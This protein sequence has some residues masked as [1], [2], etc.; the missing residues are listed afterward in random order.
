M[1]DAIRFNFSGRK[2][3]EA[4]SVLLKRQANNR[5]NY[6]RLLKLLYIADRESIRDTGFP[7]TGDTVYATKRGPVL[8]GVLDLIKSE[9]VDSALWD[10]YI[11]KDRY[12]I[13]IM[14]DPGLTALS[15]YEVQKLHLVS[16]EYA[17]RD[18]CEMCDLTNNFPELIKNK[19]DDSSR[20]LI[21]P[22]DILD[23]VERGA[24]KDCIADEAASQRVSDRI[25]AR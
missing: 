8:G 1:P 6:M 2:S 16:E 21:D 4:A 24:E 10:R 7:I 23:A 20:K 9:H 13:E 11:R 3:L 15:R 18:E 14:E 25:F 19:P 17:D 5:T 22:A 12:D